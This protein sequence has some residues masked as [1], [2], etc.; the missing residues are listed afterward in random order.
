MLLTPLLQAVVVQ[1]APYW[2]GKSV[3]ETRFHCLVAG[4]ALIGNATEPNRPYSPV[5]GKP[6]GGAAM[7]AGLT[8]ARVMVGSGSVAAS[9]KALAAM[10]S[11]GRKLAPIW[12]LAG[13]AVVPAMTS[14]A[15]TPRTIVLLSILALPDGGERRV[16]RLI[17]WKAACYTLHDLKR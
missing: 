12:M 9:P 14:I 11:D 1:R 5:R 6:R 4:R 2:L 10:V 7:V 13:L 16:G 8:L 3:E 17:L 15:A